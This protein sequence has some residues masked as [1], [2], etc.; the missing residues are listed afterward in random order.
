MSETSKI[1]DDLVAELTPVRC[2]A[3]PALRATLWLAGAAVLG[4][5]IA[6]TIGHPAALGQRLAS[7]AFAVEIS[8]TL[9][10][11]IAAV[12]AAF[13]LSVPDRPRLWALLPIVPLV[14]WLASSGSQCWHNLMVFGP[15]GASKDADHACLVFI[16]AVGVPLTLSLLIVLRR[17]APLEPVQTALLAA[18]GAGALG[19]FILQFFHP[20]DVTFLDLGFHLAGVG[21]LLVIA[22]LLASFHTRI[23][24]SP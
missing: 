4:T 15:S 9:L 3:P 21:L 20:F 5:A 22:A 17:A 6:L 7:P 11:G 1:V 10:T 8:A 14:V 19:A 13:F 24:R 16:V 2:L 23:G 18:L 12:F